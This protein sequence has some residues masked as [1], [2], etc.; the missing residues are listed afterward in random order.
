LDGKY[1]P[2]LTAFWKFAI[3]HSAY[4]P[5][6]S[7]QFGTKLNRPAAERDAYNEEEVLTFFG[8]PP[9]TGC[10]SIAHCWNEGSQYIQGYF[11]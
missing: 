9:C 10:K 6:P 8:A 5:V 2:G 3:E 11:F 7:F 4:G 1:T